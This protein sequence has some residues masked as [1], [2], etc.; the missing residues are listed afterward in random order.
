MYTGTIVTMEANKIYNI[1]VTPYWDDSYNYYIY[2]SDKTQIQLHVFTPTE[3]S[4][5]NPSLGDQTQE[6]LYNG[7]CSYVYMPLNV[8]MPLDDNEKPLL[9]ADY[10]IF[11]SENSSNGYYEM[12]FKMASSNVS[13]GFEGSKR[14]E[15]GWYYF[16]GFNSEI[17]TEFTFVIF[18]LS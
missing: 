5:S 1:I 16:T 13:S 10:Y 14:T 7:R 18:S 15:Y 6:A 9:D 2:T 11:I 8:D 3:S 12:S 4:E 17:F